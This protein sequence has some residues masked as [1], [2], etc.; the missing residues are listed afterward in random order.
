M[1]FDLWRSFDYAPL[2][3]GWACFLLGF[4]GFALG[5]ATGCLKV[6]SVAMAAIALAWRSL[7]ASIISAG[8]PK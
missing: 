2:G 5:P 4:M 1:V 3:A 7:R 8:F 6:T